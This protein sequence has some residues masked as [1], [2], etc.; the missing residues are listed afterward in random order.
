[1][2]RRSCSPQSIPRTMENLFEA[3]LKSLKQ[4]FQRRSRANAPH[5]VQLRAG[6]IIRGRS[7]GFY[8][9]LWWN[10]VKNTMKNHN[11]EFSESWVF[12]MMFLLVTMWPWDQSDN[13]PCIQMR[14]SPGVSPSWREQPGIA[15]GTC[16][17]WNWSHRSPDA[18]YARSKSL[19]YVY[20]V[21]TTWCFPFL[22][23]ASVLLSFPITSLDSTLSS[24]LHLPIS[25]PFLSDSWSLQGS[26]PEW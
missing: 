6:G 19:Q 16:E 7:L 21:G 22:V 23:V 25:S 18:F 13:D 8:N 10:Y 9:S 24:F 17:C 3:V 1:M 15:N 14:F 11:D 5:P 2:L 26:S 20:L 12:K 4:S